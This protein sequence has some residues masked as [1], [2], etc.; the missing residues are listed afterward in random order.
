MADDEVLTNAG[1]ALEWDST[2]LATF[3]EVSGI[4]M[5]IEAIEWRENTADGKSVVRKERGPLKW[6]DIT[7]KRRVTKSKALSEWLKA[8]RDGDMSAA[9]KNGSIVAKDSQ[10]N[11]VQRWNFTRGWVKSHEI[12]AGDSKSGSDMVTETVI[13]AH[14]GIEWA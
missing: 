8:A 10:R 14:E 5:E 4:K 12:S 6:D 2:E 11:E 1:F 3:T 9:R 13:I 7:L